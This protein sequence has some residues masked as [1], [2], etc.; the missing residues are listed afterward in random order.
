MREP[1]ILEADDGF[2]FIATREWAEVHLEAIDVANGEYSI[3][4]SDGFML[5]LAPAPN[6]SALISWSDS[7]ADHRA[8]LVPKLRKFFMRV[9]LSHDEVSTLDFGQLVE[10][11]V[12]RFLEVRPEPVTSR[13][14]RV[15]R[16]FLDPK[17]A[18]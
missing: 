5:T 6:G 8:E 11:G 13:I 15:I 18:R 7:P 9:G 16:S 3:Y 2:Y 14:W 4:D 1:L 12:A 10:L 17:G